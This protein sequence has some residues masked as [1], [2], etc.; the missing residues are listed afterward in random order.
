M[1]AFI[2]HQN[3]ALPYAA[4]SGEILGILKQMKETMEG[5]LSEA[6]K[7]EMS[8]AAAFAELRAAK[9]EEIAAAEKMLEDKT[10]ELAN[11]DMRLADAKEEIEETKASLDE[12][13]KFLVNLKTTCE[14]VD[15]DAALRKKN[16]L[17]EIKAINETIEILTGDEA[18]DAMNTTFNSFLQLAEQ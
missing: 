15:K 1:A 8:R 5:E 9:E 17:E 16:R 10:A 18:R 7:T 12:D 11:T 2:Q 6:Q 3:Q 4:R 14:N 13:Q